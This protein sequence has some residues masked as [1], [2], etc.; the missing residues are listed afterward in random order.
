MAT[1]S[2]GYEENLKRAI[3]DAVALDP[4]A[5]IH[6]L[7]DTLSKRLNHSF[8]PRYIKK[9]RDKVVR[10]NLVEIDR[11]KIEER[12]NFTRENYRMVR[13]ELL[14]I[15]YWT[16]QNALTG[17]PKPLARDRVEA[18]K[19]VAMLDL[20]LLKAEIECG[21]YKKPIE[22]LAKEIH[23]DPLPDDVRIVVIKSWRNFGL[24]P[25]ATIQ[26]MVP[27]KTL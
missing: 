9:L 8:D 2:H 1:Y 19:S 15:M 25:E 24:L 17:M 23:Y 7:T 6:Q 14:K 26:E 22:T 21:L 20:A 13:E 3:R 4:V 18:A 12:M 10:Q 5:G 11:I 16:P 27:E